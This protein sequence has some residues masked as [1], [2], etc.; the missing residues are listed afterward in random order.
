[1][2]RGPITFFADLGM[3]TRGYL[4]YTV[5]TRFLDLKDVI[6]TD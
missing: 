6:I 3:L 4:K 5:K 2:L 1:M